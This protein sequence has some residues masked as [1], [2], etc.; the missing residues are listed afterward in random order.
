MLQLENDQ[1]RRLLQALRGTKATGRIT[2]MIAQPSVLAG[3][4]YDIEL[5][6]GDKLY[7]PRNPS[8][9]QVIGAVLNPSSFVYDKNISFKR[10]ILMAGG[11]SREAS[12]ERVY[13]LKADGTAMRTKASA[14]A[15]TPWVKEFN[16]DIDWS[17]VEPGDAIVVP[18]K[19]ESYRGLRQT[20]DYVDIIYKVAVTALSIH[21]I[22]K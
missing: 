7:V 9:V 22:T 21:N 11:Y 6:H 14:R 20:R 12:P 1:K 13:I 10:Y 15:A 4:A 18:Q 3:S 8:T 5:E 2:T 19:I 16:D 17:L